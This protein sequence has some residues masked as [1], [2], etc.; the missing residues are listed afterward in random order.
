MAPT[1]QVFKYL[2]RYTHRVGLSNKRLLDVTDEAVTIGTR[3]GN[4]AT[5]EP[6]EFIRRRAA[7]LDSWGA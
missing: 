5:M 3:D 6:E 7:M 4:T 1:P 2:G